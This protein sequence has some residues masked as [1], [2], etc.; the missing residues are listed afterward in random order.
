MGRWRQRF[1]SLFFLVVCF[2]PPPPEFQALMISFLAGLEPTARP[3]E[4]K[5][6]PLP[7]RT[8]PPPPTRPFAPFPRT[9]LQQRLFVVEALQHDHG[10]LQKHLS[11][12]IDRSRKPHVTPR[13]QDFWLVRVSVGQ[14]DCPSFSRLQLGTK[15]LRGF[16]TVELASMFPKWRITSFPPQVSG[17]TLHS[18]PTI[19]PFWA[20]SR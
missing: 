1:L 2:S 8:T 6:P 3:T 9:R 14:R 20:F 19:R 7:H 16:S 10:L 12:A 18:N 13:A 15:L 5:P 4:N 17:R 11:P